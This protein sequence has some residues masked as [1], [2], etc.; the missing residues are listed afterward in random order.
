M[1]HAF[2]SYHLARWRSPDQTAHELGHRDTTMLYRHYRELVT[3]L[4]AR[5]FW[6]IRP[7]A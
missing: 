6:S 2:A 3:Q 7:K 1:R 5:K 4:D